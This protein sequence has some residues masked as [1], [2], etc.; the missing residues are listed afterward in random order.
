MYHVSGIPLSAMCCTER[1][2]RQ[3]LLLF[4]RDVG[5]RVATAVVIYCLAP[6]ICYLVKTQQTVHLQTSSTAVVAVAVV[7][8]VAVRV[9]IAFVACRFAV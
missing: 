8:A 4:P 5:H 6:A 7:G 9:A 3:M 1:E 2:E